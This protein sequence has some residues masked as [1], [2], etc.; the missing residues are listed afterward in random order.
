MNSSRDKL[1][2]TIVFGCGNKTE[3]TNL[4]IAAVLYDAL[5]GTKQ[6]HLSPLLFPPKELLTT[7]WCS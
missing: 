7:L 3:R 1:R 2:P 5:V 4:H 6:V